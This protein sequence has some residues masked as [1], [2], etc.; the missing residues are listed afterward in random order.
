MTFVIAIVLAKG[1][2]YPNG[3]FGWLVTQRWPVY[4]LFAIMVSCFAYAGL[5]IFHEVRIVSAWKWIVDSLST[6]Q[7]IGLMNGW[8]HLFERA[9]GVCSLQ[10]IVIAN[11]KIDDPLMARNVRAKIEYLHVGRKERLIVDRAS[12]LNSDPLGSPYP[13]ANL[14]KSINLA[15]NERQ[16]LIVYMIHKSGQCYCSPE[17]GEQHQELISGR[18]K[19]KVLITA[20]NTRSTR[21]RGILHIVRNHEENRDVVR[22]FSIS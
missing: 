1:E 15:A 18:W 12:W 9:M 22:Q 5:P 14:A 10:G 3:R 17:E 19:W 4:A 8:D 2:L 11:K 6:F 7:V 20:D 21:V 13:G 16:R